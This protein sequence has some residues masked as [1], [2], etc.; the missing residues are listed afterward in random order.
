MLKTMIDKIDSNSQIC[1]PAS[2]DEIQNKIQQL[3]QQNY[4]N[5]SM[6]ENNFISTYNDQIN[7]EIKYDSSYI[8]EQPFLLL[9]R[10]LYIAPRD[11]NYATN[12]IRSQIMKYDQINKQ[13][14]IQINNGQQPW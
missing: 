6:M 5:K 2:M 9:N 14:L 8:F 13:F 3:I 1:I 12:Y 11:T 7:N 4:S 10:Y